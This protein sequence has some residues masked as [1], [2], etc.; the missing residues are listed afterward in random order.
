MRGPEA[1]H[2]PERQPPVGSTARRYGNADLQVGTAARRAAKPRTP[3]PP[4]RAQA[5][6]PLPPLRDPGGLEARQEELRAGDGATE[7]D[8]RQSHPRGPGGGPVWA[9]GAAGVRLARLADASI[10]AGHEFVTR[11]RAAVS[12]FNRSPGKTGATERSRRRR[13]SGPQRGRHLHRSR[14]R[15]A[16]DSL[17]PALAGRLVPLRSA[18]RA[19]PLQGARRSPGPGTCSRAP[20]GRPG[21]APLQRRSRKNPDSPRRAGR[22]TAG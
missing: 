18:D 3:H 6:D 13:G 22:R 5:R 16:Q 2:S 4:H 11:Y 15:G 10:R 9:G 8:R 17:Q 12:V 20:S 21:R 7:T 1:A 14:N 19:Q